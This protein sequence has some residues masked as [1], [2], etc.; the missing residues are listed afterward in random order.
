[1]RKEVRRRLGE[2][3]D[4]MLEVGLDRAI[5]MRESFDCRVYQTLVGRTF[6][7]REYTT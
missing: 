5:E 6:R 1:M 4:Y 2:E 3:E 7:R